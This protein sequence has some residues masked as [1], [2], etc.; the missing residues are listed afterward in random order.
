MLTI[1][2]QVLL[3]NLEAMV[4][5]H[6]ATPTDDWGWEGIKIDEDGHMSVPQGAQLG[7]TMIC[8]NSIYEGYELDCRYVQEACT[9][10]PRLLNAIEELQHELALIKGDNIA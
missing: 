2:T 6:L 9:K 1:G 7:E 4:E 8:L 10:F 5:I 3:D